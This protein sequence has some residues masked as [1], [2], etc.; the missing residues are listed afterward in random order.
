[1]RAVAVIEFDCYFTL[2]AE[3]VLFGAIVGVKT[4]NGTIVGLRNQ[5]K[6]PDGERDVF[7]EFTH[8]QQG[9]VPDPKQGG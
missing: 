8:T 7:T 9:F 6:S 2:N 5:I 1:V 3:E 4:P